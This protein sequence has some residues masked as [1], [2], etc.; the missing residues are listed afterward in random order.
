MMPSSYTFNPSI[1]P[2][3]I[4]LDNKPC[5]NI[6]VQLAD[7]QSIVAILLI[8]LYFRVIL[9]AVRSLALAL[10]RFCA[11]AGRRPF[12]FIFPPCSLPGEVTLLWASHCNQAF[13]GILVEFYRKKSRQTLEGTQSAPNDLK[14]GLRIV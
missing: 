9:E 7:T 3:M 2:I 5:I 8:Q 1:S 6:D 12:F 11:V 14:I 13:S 10:F 4:T